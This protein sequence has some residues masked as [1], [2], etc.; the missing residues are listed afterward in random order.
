MMYVMIRRI[1]SRVAPVYSSIRRFQKF[2]FTRGRMLVGVFIGCSTQVAIFLQ[3][4]KVQ[5]ANL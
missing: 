5:T 2:T 3:H 1:G 4:T